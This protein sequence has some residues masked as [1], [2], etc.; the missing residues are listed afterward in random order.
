VVRGA[1]DW[2]N[3]ADTVLYLRRDATLG[4]LAVVVKHGKHRVGPKHAPMWFTLEDVI[5]G[6]A[7]RLVYGGAYDDESGQGEAAGLMSAVLVL[8]DALKASSS[9]LYVKGLLDQVIA[10]GT[11]KASARRALD[12]L[13][14][15]KPWPGGALRGQKRSVVEEDK[16]GR[17]VFLTFLA[18]QWPTD[19][20]DDDA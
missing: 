19:D 10:G 18:A 7:A 20:V 8:V 15:K 2:R 14:G 6:K 16:H 4:R 12:I 13:R 9:G 5:P 17:S 1:G 3:A 11:S